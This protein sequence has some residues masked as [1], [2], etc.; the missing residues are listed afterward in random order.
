MFPTEEKLQQDQ[1]K[2][3]ALIV[4]LNSV[5]SRLSMGGYRG[6]YGDLLEN[7]VITDV[8]VA[9]EKFTGSKIQIVIR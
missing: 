7:S 3:R 1:D 8:I 5:T 2:I 4:G 6:G 9:L